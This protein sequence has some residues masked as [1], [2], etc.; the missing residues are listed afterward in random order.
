MGVKFNKILGEISWNLTSFVCYLE[1]W[2]NGAFWL[3][4][5]S[6]H[7]ILQWDLAKR[8]MMWS[9]HHVSSFSYMK[10]AWEYQ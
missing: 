3:T 10:M 7:M 2:E 9:F 5:K 6:G 8:K 1:T 4:Q